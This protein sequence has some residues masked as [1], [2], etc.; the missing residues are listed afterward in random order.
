MVDTALQAPAKPKVRG[1]SG[2]GMP[3]R[4]G[5]LLGLFA[6]RF[7]DH[8]P[9]PTAM[10]DRL[11]MLHAEGAV[12]VYVHR[13]RNPVEH[14][15]LSRVVARAGLPMARYVGGLSVLGLQPFWSLPAW[16]SLRGN[17]PTREEVLLERC[18]RAGLPAEIFF[19]FRI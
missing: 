6:H 8:I 7:L 5:P 13:A 4:L 16:L 9:F 15:A 18:V 19:T 10:A 2:R 1:L 12:L 11:K 17:N 3:R 14:L